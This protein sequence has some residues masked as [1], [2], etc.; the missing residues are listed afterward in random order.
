MEKLLKGKE[1]GDGLAMS[2]LPDAIATADAKM[3]LLEGLTP[4]QLAQ[5]ERVNRLLAGTAT[6]DDLGSLGASPGAGIARALQRNAA[7]NDF[8]YRSSGGRGIV[9]PI[10][11]EDQVI[12]MKAGGPIANATGR[13]T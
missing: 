1:L 3:R 13:G 8:I 12:G 4:E 11:R 7:A 6:S 9:T 5:T 10:N 2:A